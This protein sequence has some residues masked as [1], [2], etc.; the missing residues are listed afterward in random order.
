M[1]KFWEGE[2]FDIVCGYLICRSN[3]SVYN[4]RIDPTMVVKVENKPDQFQNIIEQQTW[5]AVR[6]DPEFAKWFA[7]V[8]HL[9]TNGKILLMSKVEP[10]RK[11]ER[12]KKMPNFL[13]DFRTSNYGM[14]E[15]RVV[16]C[17]YGM[18]AT[19]FNQLPTN[20]VKVEWRED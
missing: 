20:L 12:P 14:F 3:R 17:D 5:L 7:P 1:S 13:T 11:S 15:G 9:S 19:R 4:C 18:T 10:I 2:Y 16:C 6:D 8:H